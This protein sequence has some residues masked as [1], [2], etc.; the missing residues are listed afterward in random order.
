VT[1]YLLSALAWVLSKLPQNGF[2]WCYVIRTV[3]GDPYITRILLP[4]LGGARR[5]IHRIHR[6]DDR[7]M[8]NHPW[9]WATTRILTGGYLEERMPLCQATGMCTPAGQTPRFSPCLI[10]P[11]LPEW[12]W[13]RPGD[14]ATLDMFDF[15]RIATVHDR[16]WTLFTAGERVQRWGFATEEG[17]VDFEEY[18]AR[19]GYEYQ[20]VKS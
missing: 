20:G 5:M 17:F 18:F 11:E 2:L 16:T 15:H 7:V 13:R 12:H 14:T 1:H 9:E 4:R 6:A 3:D 10:C 8:H 19:K